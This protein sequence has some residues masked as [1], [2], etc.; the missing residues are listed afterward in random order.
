MKD[1]ICVGV[2]GSGVISEIYLK[3]MTT[4]FPKLRV[5]S[6]A[7]KHKE[8]AQARADQFGIACCT[9]DELLADPEIDLVVNLTPL[10]A[11]YDLIKAALMAGK[12]VYTEKTLTNDLSQAAELLALAKEKNLYLGSAP[13][14]FLGASIQTAKSVLADGTIGDVTGFVITT[15]RDWGILLNVL[16]FLRE[17][18]PGMC[19][20]FAV[21]HITA[22]VNLLGPVASVAAMNTIPKPYHFMIPDSPQFGQELVCPNETRVSA[23]LSMKNGITGTMM[24]DGDSVMKEQPL[25]RIYGTKGILELEDPNQFGTPVRLMIPPRDPRLPAEYTEVAQVNPYSDNFRGIGISDMADAILTGRTSRVDAQLAYH[26]MDVL[27]AIL[28]SG[29]TRRFVDV[30]SGCTIP[31]PL[32]GS[33]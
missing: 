23:I 19:Y 8:H 5:K 12:H 13:E 33:L 4:Q 3:N 27:T 25:F 2:I 10:S 14:T 6:I 11:H 18:G 26:V 32:T 20:D 30:T 17:K 22:L 15:N 21:Y 31:D 28:K 1:S 16:P 9:V 24:M 7:S 29:E